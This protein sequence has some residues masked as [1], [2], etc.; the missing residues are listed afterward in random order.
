MTTSYLFWIFA[1]LTL[2][3]ALGAYNRLMRLRTDWVQAL[4]QLS[5]QWQAH[6]QAVLQALT[7][8][9]SDAMLTDT[10]AAADNWR[11]LALSAGQ[12]QICV[13]HM[14]AY[15]QA[16]PLA[17]D[18]AGVHTAYGVMFTAWSNLRNEG[19]DLAGAT[20]P[21]HLHLLWQ[22]HSM[23]V[24]EKRKQ[25]NKCVLVYNQAIAQFPA[26]VVAW[27]FGFSIAHTI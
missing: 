1:A 5:E 23:R 11:Q 12:L 18:L 27:V 14:R 20:V 24:D 8:G 16:I 19:D 17:D 26:R 4:Q 13:A 22:Q 2:F 6:A 21:P 3:W 10:E 15:P 7:H 9:L 25:H